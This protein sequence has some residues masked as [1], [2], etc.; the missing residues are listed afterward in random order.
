MVFVWLVIGIGIVTR[1]SKELLVLK[2]IDYLVVGEL[3]RKIQT[4]NYWVI[5]GV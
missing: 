5:H 4:N 1:L 3:C 2:D